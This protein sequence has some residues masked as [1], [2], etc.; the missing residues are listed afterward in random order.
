MEEGGKGV[1]GR[2]WILWKRKGQI[3]LSGS[4]G[5]AAYK[6]SVLSTVSDPFTSEFVSQDSYFTCQIPFYSC[7]LP[8][9]GFHSHY[10]STTLSTS[11]ALPSPFSFYPLSK[12]ALSISPFILVPHNSLSRRECVNATFFPSFELFDPKQMCE[13]GGKNKN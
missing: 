1:K 11:L 8:L 7:I 12:P 5:A 6:G 2:D 9:F 10:F 4:W 3:K 13:E